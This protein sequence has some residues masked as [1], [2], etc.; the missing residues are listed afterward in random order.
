[1]SANETCEFLKTIGLLEA[2]ERLQTYRCF[3]GVLFR[4]FVGSRLSSP[5]YLTRWVVVA[6]GLYP[7]LIVQTTV[8]AYINELEQL[9]DNGVFR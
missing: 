7:L 6:E 3:V 4:L 9:L 2:G 5:L 8:L 1:M